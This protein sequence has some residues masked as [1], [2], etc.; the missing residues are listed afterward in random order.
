MKQT[1]NYKLN[2]P[3]GTDS[4]DIE[5]ENANMRI[6]DTQMKK[7]ADG[8]ATI[9]DV[10][11]LKTS[12]KDTTVNA[13]NEVKTRVDTINGKTTQNL[14]YT[15]SHTSWQGNEYRK[16]EELYPHTQYDIEIGVDATASKEQAK[17][18]GVADMRNSYNSNVLTA[19]NIAPTIDIV[20]ALKLIKK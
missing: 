1:T 18:W 7:N 13:I 2:T 11:S 19:G 17:A 10:S 15:V 14:L 3:D 4:Y 16:L 8:V 12:A 9:G 20:C 5:N 6:I